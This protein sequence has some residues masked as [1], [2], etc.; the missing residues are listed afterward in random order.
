[1]LG[2]ALAV[3]ARRLNGTAMNTK[4][5]AARRP[6][7]LAFSSRRRLVTYVVGLGVWTSGALWV[8]FNYFMRSEGRFGIEDHPLQRWWLVLHGAFSFASLWIFGLIWSAHVVTGWN[9]RWRR[10]S[11]GTLV[12]IIFLLTITGYA[13]YYL[14]GRDSRSWTSLVHWIIGL[15]AMAVFLIHWLS[16]AKPRTNSSSMQSRSL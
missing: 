2:K 12:G 6:S 15:G 3:R 7:R 1:M 9:A 13:L 16:R 14:T 4:Q 5:S 11:G 8:F 10:G